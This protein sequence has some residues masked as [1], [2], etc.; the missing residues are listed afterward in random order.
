MISED[1]S[2]VKTCCAYIFHTYFI[3][4]L[5]RTPFIFQSKNSYSFKQFHDYKK[6]SVVKSDLILYKKK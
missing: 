5:S 1:G 6:D 4:Y 3:S 2:D